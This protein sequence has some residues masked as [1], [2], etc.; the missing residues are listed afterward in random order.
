[1]YLNALL[2]ITTARKYAPS[3][4]RNPVR[5]KNATEM[6]LLSTTSG[7]NSESVDETNL[8]TRLFQRVILGA[9]DF[10]SKQTDVKMLSANNVEHIASHVGVS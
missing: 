2:S 9:F 1:M 8:S 4:H 7:A 3:K 10:H 5:L 6:E